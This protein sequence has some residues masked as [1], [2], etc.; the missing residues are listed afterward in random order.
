MKT[1]NPCRLLVVVMS[2]FGALPLSACL[3]DDGGEDSREVFECCM[4]SQIASGVRWRKA[5]IATPAT[6]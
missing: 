3:E 1:K 5:V 6:P 2:L 4:L